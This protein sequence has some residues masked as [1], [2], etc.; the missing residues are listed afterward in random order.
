MTGPKFFI[1]ILVLLAVLFIVGVGIG[2]RQN[3]A[4]PDARNFSPPDWTSSLGDWLSPSLDLTTVQTVAGACLQAA[5]KT[6]TLAANSNC[7]LQVPA[8]SK[9]YRKVKLHLVTGASVDVSYSSPTN[10]PN[11]KQKDLVWP[12]KDPQTLLVLAGGGSIVLSCGSATSCMLQV[13]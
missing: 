9:K 12:G 2:L 1:I 6:F 10:D 8:A 11:L 13:Q 5:Q 3:D 7:K 4:Q